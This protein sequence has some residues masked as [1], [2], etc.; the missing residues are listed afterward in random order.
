MSHISPTRMI[1]L[2]FLA[3][4]L[5]GGILLMLP[6]SSADRNA[7]SASDAFF[8]AVSAT[9]ITGLAVR[10]TMTEW[11]RFGHTAILCMVQI[12]GLGFMT[13]TVL[14]SILLKRRIT[15]RER[16]ILAES[17]NLNT[18][19]G[20]MK[21][22]RM[23]L[24][25]TLLIELAGA[26]IL[27]T[28]FIPLFGVGE[29]IYRA[30]FHSISSFCNAGFDLMGD[31][32]GAYSSLVGFAESP[33]VL[34]TK[35]ILILLGG[36][37][38]V[39]WEDILS[40]LRNRSRLSIY[41]R[42][43]LGLTVVL[44][45]GGS[46]IFALLEWN[47]PETIGN[48]TPAYKLLNAV[49]Y[50]VSLRT[51]G[52]TTFNIMELNSA[53]MLISCI[54]MFIG[55]ASGSAAGGIKMVTFWL[56]LYSALRIAQG[57]G[58]INI[59]GRKIPLRSVMRALTV[60]I[61]GILCIAAA[62]IVLSLSEEASLTEVLYECIAAFTTTGISMSITPTLSVIGRL[63]VMLLMFMGR[64]GILTVTFSIMLDGTKKKS[65]ITYPEIQLMIG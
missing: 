54:W 33:I 53:S 40:F 6:I 47:N 45:V 18:Y 51:A 8:T 2:G 1:I 61:I 52:F 64:V 49:F 59:F 27:A 46:L 65:C 55:G 62:A 21:L 50:A 10:D 39:V 16:I 34:L 15:P 26:F 60:T 63:V 25:G 13:F 12:G 57:Y 30:V 14:V 23:I 19:E 38:F 36:I 22:I 9:C 44:V 7:A 35:A 32:S 24:I 3:V 17:F 37:G 20:I 5:V 28:Q 41:T 56:L 4:I 48:M 58:E 29:G 43:V 42:L 11:S 31:Y